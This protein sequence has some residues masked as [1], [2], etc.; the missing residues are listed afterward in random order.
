M[1]CPKCNTWVTPDLVICPNEKCRA[2]LG[3][4]ARPTGGSVFHRT[5]IDIENDFRQRKASVLAPD[6]GGRELSSLADASA[7]ALARN[8]MGWHRSQLDG[9]GRPPETREAKTA[10]G[11]EPL[12]ERATASEVLLEA[13][14][15]GVLNLL[16]LHAGISPLRRL[17]VSSSSVDG[18]Q[19]CR[20]RLSASPAVFAPSV[21]DLPRSGGGGEVDPPGATPDFASFFALDEAVRGQLELAVLYENAP[22]A[23]RTFPVTVQNPNEWIA[24]QG[25]EA[26]LAGVVTPNAPAI[27]KFVSE[28]SGDFVAYQAGSSGRVIE[29]AGI[30]YEGIRRLGLSYIG[31]PPSFEGT[32]Q[33]VLFPDE[34]IATGRGCCID[35][36]T[37]TAAVLE[38]LGLNPVIVA[39][40]GHAYAG[41]WT[42]EMRAK[43]PVLRDR[44]SVVDQV[45]EGNLLVWNS[46]TYFDRQGDDSFAS[47]VEI[48][49]RYLE[50]LAFIIDIAA[51]RQHG[52]KPVPRRTK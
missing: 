26:S 23:E 16:L 10:P 17:A 38:R 3:A 11:P 8:Q 24:R 42:T 44:Q 29:E 18:L 25:A 21:I 47:A 7:D 2:S 37:L 1:R 22:L 6:P 27:V 46:T 28:L 48:G 34:V 30:V 13:E 32:G 45:E 15:L 5:S 51:C 41:V 49:R 33:K 36:A 50:K 31:V 20:L 35:I 9:A 12:L 4:E 14:P 40:A 19:G 52:L 39:V 43:Q